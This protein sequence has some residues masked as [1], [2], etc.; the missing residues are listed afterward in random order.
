MLRRRIAWR[1]G[2]WQKFPNGLLVELTKNDELTSPV[3][4][5]GRPHGDRQIEF[6]EL[7]RPFQTRS[8]ILLPHR[9]LGCPLVLP[10]DIL[11]RGSDLHSAVVEQSSKKD[12]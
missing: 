11:G 10:G 1:N 3:T 4:G 12:R 5:L 8:R 9:F 2:R 6:R 7:S